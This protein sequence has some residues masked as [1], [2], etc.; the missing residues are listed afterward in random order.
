ME[1]DKNE[2]PEVKE[3]KNIC[4]TSSPTSETKGVCDKVKDEKK[5]NKDQKLDKELK[6]TFPASDPNAKY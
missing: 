3:L 6:D 4:E 5:K 2:H 1:K